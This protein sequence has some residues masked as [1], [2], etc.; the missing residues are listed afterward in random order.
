MNEIEVKAHLKNKE[1]IMQNLRDKGCVFEDAIVQ[2]DTVFTQKIGSFEIYD[3]NEIFLRIRIKNNSKIIFTAKKTL[4]TG[5]DCLEYET[6]ISSYKQMYDALIIMGY[7]EALRINKTRIITHYNGC[8]ICIDEV[9]D[10]GSFIEMEKLC[11]EGDSKKIQE[12]LFGFL[13]SV[14]VSKDDRVFNGY[15]DLLLLKKEKS[16]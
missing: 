15:D 6:E 4:H 9:E 12:E 14:G 2:N 13:Q 3:T 16:I 7:K 10:L 11:E 1:I 5:L 8:E